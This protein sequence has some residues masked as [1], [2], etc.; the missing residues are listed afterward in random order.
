L[1]LIDCVEPS[2][3]NTV[4]S[5]SPPVSTPALNIGLISWAHAGAVARIAPASASATIASVTVSS[6]RFMAEPPFD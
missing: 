2:V 5:L 1:A 4:T 3:N 6:V